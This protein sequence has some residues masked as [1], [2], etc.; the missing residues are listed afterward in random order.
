MVMINEIRDKKETK[1]RDAKKK[2]LLSP[3]RDTRTRREKER[4]RETTKKK[5]SQWD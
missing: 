5:K 4:R 2:Q 3:V 1:I